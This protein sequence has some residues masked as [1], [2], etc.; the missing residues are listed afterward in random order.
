MGTY[1]KCQSKKE[2]YFDFKTHMLSILDGYI[3][4]LVL[5]DAGKDDRSV[6]WDL[7]SLY[8]SLTIRGDKGYIVEKLVLELKLEEK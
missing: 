2:I 4:E 1:D 3:K 7:V 6:V 8:N 5:I